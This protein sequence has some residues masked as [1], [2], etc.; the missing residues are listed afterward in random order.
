MGI[1]M[2]LL[3]MLLQ[4]IFMI[5]AQA[6]VSSAYKKYSRVPNMNGVAGVE[7]A[8]TLLAYNSLDEVKIEGARGQLSDHYD[9][10]HK[11]LRL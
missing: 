2:Y 4:L 9:P 8:R 5:W 6:R 11:V 10:R 3:F 7:A 1:M